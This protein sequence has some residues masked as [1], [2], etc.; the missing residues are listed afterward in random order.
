MPI[1]GSNEYGNNNTSENPIDF[2]NVHNILA[3]DAI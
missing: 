2:S 3:G 1:T